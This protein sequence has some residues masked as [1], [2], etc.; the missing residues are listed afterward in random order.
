MKSFTLSPA[1]GRQAEAVDDD[2]Q[3]CRRVGVLLCPLP[4]PSLVLGA[5]R[6]EGGIGIGHKAQADLV[7]TTMIRRRSALLPLLVVVVV[8]SASAFTREGSTLAQQ[9][10]RDTALMLYRSAA[11]AIYEA[12][13]IC[14][15]EG[16]DS[17]R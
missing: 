17:E 9:Q 2:M 8:T 1:V 7:A 4:L 16:P 12:E 10:R 14:A 11:E 15:L 3:A 5:E 13:E 6:T